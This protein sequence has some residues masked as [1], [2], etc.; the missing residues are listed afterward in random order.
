VEGGQVSGLEY[1]TAS[2]LPPD[3]DVPAMLSAAQWLGLMLWYSAVAARECVCGAGSIPYMGRGV[4]FEHR[5][6]CP[7]DSLEVARIV[8]PRSYGQH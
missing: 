4:S 2:F 3:L 5:R 8:W 6:D 1:R 7:A